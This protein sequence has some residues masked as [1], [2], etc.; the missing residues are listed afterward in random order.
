MATSRR[1]FLKTGTMGLLCAGLPLGLADAVIGRSTSGG[2]GANGFTRDAFAPYVGTTF[3]IKA[4]SASVNLR[5]AKITD[6]KAISKTP[7]RIAGRESFSLLFEGSSK[8]P[9]LAQDTRL[10]QHQQ[11]GSFSL[12]LVP[13]GKPTSRH[14][15]AIIIRL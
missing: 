1:N 15:E 6:L 4:D 12:F 11:L 8:A 5:L 13:V 3:R 7:S 2:L 10:V 14:Y 9:L